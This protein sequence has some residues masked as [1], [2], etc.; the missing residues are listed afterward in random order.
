MPPARITL[1][2]ILY[3]ALDLATPMI[4]GI[5]PLIGV[6]LDP[7]EGSRTRTYMVSIPT[8]EPRHLSPDVPQREH[9][10]RETRWV[11]LASALKVVRSCPSFEPSPSAAPPSTDDD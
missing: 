10:P 9:V 1:A 11:T 6:S 8:V 7:V 4:P 3:L 5:V 2:V